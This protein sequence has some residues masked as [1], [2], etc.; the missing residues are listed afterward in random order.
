MKCNHSRPGFELE[1]PCPFPTTITIT[2]QAPLQS[3]YSLEGMRPPRD[4]TVNF[5]LTYPEKMSRRYLT[6]FPPSQDTAQ[7]YF[8]VKSHAWIETHI[9][10]EQKM[11]GSI[12][13][14]LLG[15]L[16]CQAMNSAL[17]IRYCLR[18]WSRET[19]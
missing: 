6:D 8:K 2:P 18:K 9:R 3:R 1:S 14:S 5:S 7:G 11:L 19:W 10:P 16:K 17:Q 15:C 12:G 4:L 13:I